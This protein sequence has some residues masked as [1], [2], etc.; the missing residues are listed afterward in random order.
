MSNLGAFGGVAGTEARFE[1][2]VEGD[3]ECAVDGLAQ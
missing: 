1:G 2:L 3:L